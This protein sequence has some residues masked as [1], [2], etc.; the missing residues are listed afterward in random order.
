M[1]RV[2]GPAHSRYRRRLGD[3]AAGGRTV[4]I[5]PRVGGSSAVTRRVSGGRRSA[6][7]R[8]PG[9]GLPRQ[10][11][12]TCSPLRAALTARVL[13]PPSITVREVTRRMTSHKSQLGRVKDRS[14]QLSATAGHVTAF[15]EMITGCHGERLSGG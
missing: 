2:L 4:M 15:A 9:L 6:I 7:H 13:P 1:R 10:R 8:D 5:D 3:L 14:A 12:V 11:A